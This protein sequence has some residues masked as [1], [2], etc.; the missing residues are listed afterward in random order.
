M[1]LERAPLKV[2][3]SGVH[4][5]ADPS[6]GLGIARSLR[7]AF[8]SAILTA[9]DYS[10]R[11]SGL[12]DPVFDEVIIQPTWSEL[13]LASYMIKIVGLLQ[14]PHTYW[15][16]GLDAEINWLGE[17]A[18]QHQ[19]LLTP[20][21]AALGA[22]RKP[23]LSC[24][25]ALDMRVPSYLSALAPPTEIHTLGRH[26]GWRLWAKGTLHEAYRAYDYPSLR[27]QIDNL[28]TH[29]P[30]DQIFLQ[31]HIRGHERSITFCAWRGILL[32]AVEVE[33]RMVTTQG[34]TWAA[35]VSA[36]SDEIRERL[37]HLAHDLNYTGGGEVEFVRDATGEDWLIDFNPRFPAYIHGV[38]ICGHNLPA[39]LVSSAL[40]LPSPPEKGH[41]SQFIRVVS[42]IPVR[43]EL[44]LLETAHVPDSG[45]RAKHPSY[46]PQLVR[47]LGHTEPRR[48]PLHHDAWAND[49]DLPGHLR[50]VSTT[51]SRIRDLGAIERAVG[52]LERSMH[53]CANEPAILPA[54]SVKTDPCL[55]IADA[56]L[57]RGWWAEVISHDELTWA[58]SA[59]FMPHE[60]VFNGPLVANSAERPALPVAVS[61]ADSVESFETLIDGSDSKAVGLRIRSHVGSRFGVDLRQPAMFN[62]VVSMLRAART[63]LELGLHMHLAAD[64]VGPAGWLDSLHHALAWGRALEA[65]TGRSFSVFDIG[66]GWHPDDLTHM[67]IGWLRSIQT[68]VVRSLPEVQTLLIEP[69]K[70]IATRSAWL[71]TRI[72]EVRVSGGTLEVVVDASIADLPMANMYPQPIMHIRDGRSIGSLSGGTHRVLG[73]ICMETDVLADGIDFQTEPR[74]GDLLAFSGAGGYNASMSWHFARGVSRDA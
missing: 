50:A 42:E 63:D 35:S 62:Q 31:R 54:M 32:D 52:L 39:A 28:A 64:L 56:F 30:R 70:S 8:P 67:P 3:V 23:V 4:S 16:S 53:D 73:A 9:V 24:A 33:K 58:M 44:L 1:T 49:M 7:R 74:T 41:T 20:A 27:H 25:S 37:V 71:V 17:S 51:P 38:T 48:L 36:V 19:G 34:K 14:D 57:R 60:I 46:Q 55:P 6:P 45:L 43:P 18:D 72:I 47:Q 40:G 22:L 61:F 5:D 69:G 11:S 59:G 10:S 21:E 68:Q 12:H 2:Y 15:I 66:G 13:D 26:S 29:W 65:S